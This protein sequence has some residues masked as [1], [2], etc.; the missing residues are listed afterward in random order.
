[1]DCASATVTWSRP[2]EP[3]PKLEWLSDLTYRERPLDEQN[4]TYAMVGQ[5]IE[6]L[7]RMGASDGQLSALAEKGG[8]MTFGDIIAVYFDNFRDGDR[9]DQ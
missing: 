6:H 4:L 7:A 8:N 3:H 2:D 9:D 1:M 5:A